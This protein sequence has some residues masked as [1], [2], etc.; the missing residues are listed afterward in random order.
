MKKITGGIRQ[1]GTRFEPCM[2]EETK[3]NMLYVH[4]KKLTIAYELLNLGPQT[5]LESRRILVCGGYHLDCKYITKG[6]RREIIVRN[7]RRL[8]L[9]MEHALVGTIGEYLFYLFVGIGKEFQSS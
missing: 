3:E 4:C 5:S 7:V 9:G 8:I 1:E 6:P 2:K